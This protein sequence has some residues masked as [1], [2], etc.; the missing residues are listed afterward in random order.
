MGSTDF[1]LKFPRLTRGS[2]DQAQAGYEIRQFLHMELERGGIPE[3]EERKQIS[4]Q[5]GVDRVEEKAIQTAIG[6]FGATALEGA[7][8]RQVSA[9][10]LSSQAKHEEEEMLL[11]CLD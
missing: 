11:D 6:R 4:A 3:R 1:S 8:T 7:S 5:A 9:S 10:H 2:V